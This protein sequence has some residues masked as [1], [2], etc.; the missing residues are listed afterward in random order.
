MERINIVIFGKTNVGKSSF[1]N[2]ITSQDISIVSDVK[3]TTTDIVEKIIEFHPFGPVRFF[4]TAGIDDTT[5]LSQKRIQKTL[6]IIPR[7][8]VGILICS[9]NGINIS[10]F[11]V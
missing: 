8:N 2:A 4:D 7:I 6:S 1:L 3:G 5:E 11:R 10:V 9:F